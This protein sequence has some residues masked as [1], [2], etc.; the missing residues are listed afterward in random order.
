MAKS[1][2]TVT[3]NPAVD[4]SWQI[5]KFTPGQDHWVPPA[6]ASAGGKGINVSRALQKLGLPTRTTGFLGGPSGKYIQRALNQET[7][8]H[9]FI[10]IR[11]ETRISLTII[12]TSTGQ[13]T[14]ILEEGPK[15]SRKEVGQ[16]RRA[17][18]RM[19]KNSSHVV[20]S[21]RNIPGAGQDFYASLIR[22][23]RRAGKKTILDTSGPALAAG[24]KAK[25]SLIKPN[26]AE[27]QG[28]LKYK[29]DTVTNLQRGL[30]YFRRLG[31][32][33]VIISLGEEGVAAAHA[34]ELWRVT[35]PRIQTV[36]P[37]GSG[38]A[39]IAGFLYAESRKLGFV[40]CLKMAVAA[41]TAN[42]L[43]MTPGDLSRAEVMK[44]FQGVKA[45]SL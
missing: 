27:A 36:N 14:R 41:G 35:P 40:E 25:P 5:V 3:L 13:S 18:A 10:P 32:E 4:K 33:T 16:F 45:S 7:I 9:R 19:L 29:L 22:T 6:Q 1:I 17:F 30:Q 28:V 23:A 11:G 44:I 39:L 2:L 20:F 15:V 24:L 42:A 31:I 12:E 8:A 34:K 26:R 37:V 21:G 43:T 38:D